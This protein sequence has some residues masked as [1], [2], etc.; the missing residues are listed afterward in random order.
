M[1]ARELQPICF[2]RVFL[3]AVLTAK[4]A[5]HLMTAT[6]DSIRQFIFRSLGE[7]NYD[8][9]GIDDDSQLGPRGADLA[10]LALVELALRVEDEFSVKFSEEEAE[11]LAGKTVGEFCAIVAERLPADGATAESS[12]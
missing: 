9:E 5:D 4:G 8:T 3:Q 11:E 6:T 7:M 10:S 2:G 1:E 12:T